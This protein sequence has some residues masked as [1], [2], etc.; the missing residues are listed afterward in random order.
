VSTRLLLAAAVLAW[1]AGAT[2]RGAEPT[3]DSLDKNHDGV[4]SKDE[5]AAMLPSQNGSDSDQRRSGQG[6]G[7]GGGFG[8]RG[9]AGGFGGGFGGGGFGGRGGMHSGGGMG[10]G[11]AQGGTQRSNRKTQS[12]DEIF[13]S[14][15]KDGNGTISRE[16]FDSRPRASSRHGGAANTQ[17]PAHA[18]PQ[19]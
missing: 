19:L 16:E 6:Q 14:W 12:A 10:G 8:M 11:S 3:F 13:K 15:D 2:A 9:G 17:D 1:V 7:G 18:P 4:L 5:V